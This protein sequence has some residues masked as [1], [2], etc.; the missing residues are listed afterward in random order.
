MYRAVT[1]KIA[2]DV[3]PF[4]LDQHEVTNQERS[5]VSNADGEYLVTVHWATREAAQATM[6]AF[7]SAPETQGF[8]GA[9]DTGTVESGSYEL[10]PG[11]KS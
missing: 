1:R 3:E 2:V 6:G 5:V 10:V 8:L 9:V 7:F 11:P 4:Y